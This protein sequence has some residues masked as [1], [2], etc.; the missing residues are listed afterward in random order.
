MLSGVTQ[1]TFLESRFINTALLDKGRGDFFI[2]VSPNN[3][4]R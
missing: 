1:L 3:S 2:R 4:E